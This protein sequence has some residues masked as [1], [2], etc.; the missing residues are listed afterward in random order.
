MYILSLKLQGGNKDKVLIYSAS[1]TSILE[2][3]VIWHGDHIPHRK[4][5]QARNYAA[6]LQ[7]NRTNVAPAASSPCKARGNSL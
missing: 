1:Y 5:R 7:G 6:L 4:F 3:S 2:L